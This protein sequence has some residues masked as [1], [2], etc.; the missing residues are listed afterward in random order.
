MT[1]T[2][3]FQKLVNALDLEALP[4]EEQN[5]LLLDLN[6]VIFKKSLVRMIEN[7]D[8]AT[9][10]EFAA[11]MENGASEEE[12]ETFLTTKVPGAEEAV[13]EAVE[14]LTDDILAVSEVA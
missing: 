2:A 8:E 4:L 12:I 10:E 1:D 7:M 6:S 9:R 14:T 13:Q 11:L 5:E 3:R